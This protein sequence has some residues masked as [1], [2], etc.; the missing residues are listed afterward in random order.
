[1]SIDGSKSLGDA[2][3]PLIARGRAADVYAYG[4]GL[5]LRRYRTPHSC[6][7]EAAVMQ[8]V[9]EYGYPVP[10]VLEVSGNDIVMER[11]SG[12][13][14]LEDFSRR[15]WRLFRHANTLAVLLTTLH[16]IPAPPWLEPKLGGGDKIV[17]LDL[18][19]DNVLITGEGPVVIDWTNAG[20]G[21]PD[22]EVADLW[23]VSANAVIPGGVL[24]RRFLGAGRGLFVN[25][26]LRY[27][28]RDAVRRHVRV[29]A[30]HRLRDRNMLDVER[31]R[32][33]RFVE[34]WAL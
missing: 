23:I 28:D 2:P 9:R 26:W 21:H 29:A 24:K 16:A 4:D 30:G 34:R 11:V 20:R 31:E 14:M 17:H 3:G 8:H 18:H 6:L 19:P 15:P 13:T 22:A 32:I 25:A 12:P 33:V 5:I 27:F 7:Y 1:M 10:A